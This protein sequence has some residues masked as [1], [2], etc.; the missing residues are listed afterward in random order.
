M[1]EFNE[2]QIEKQLS[3]LSASRDSSL[4][5]GGSTAIQTVSA[6][7]CSEAI[8]QHDSAFSLA[9]A[10]DVG[11]L[12]SQRI[13][14]PQVAKGAAQAKGG[15]NGKGAPA[16]GGKKGAPAPPPMDQDVD[17][18]PEP[19][20]MAPEPVHMA[21]EPVVVTPPAKGKG[22]GGK[23]GAPSITPSAPPASGKGVPAAP[24]GKGVPAAPGGGKGGKA[25]PPAAG[26]KGKPGVKGKGKGKGA[27]STRIKVT[28]LPL[29]RRVNLKEGLK[30]E[31]LTKSIWAEG[32]EKIRADSQKQLDDEYLR[33]HFRKAE[34]VKL[35]IVK[36]EDSED[37][38]VTFFSSGQIQNFKI[39]WSQMKNKLN[40]EEIV[41]SLHTLQP[42]DKLPSEELIR[43][44]DVIPPLSDMKNLAEYDGPEE[45]LRETER[46]LYP[47]SLNNKSY[48]KIK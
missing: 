45:N 26:G 6:T 2:I 11:F 34:K 29:N 39:V 7:S 17:M 22:K 19:R 42:F 33:S 28:D 31:D 18:A 44:C 16:K 12:E 3:G 23:P 30:S 24:G 47:I 48:V 10:S 20:D 21:P 38:E 8:L 43:F 46:L 36:K 15:K 4:S 40:I 13:E 35:A 14:I 9:S 5:P 37:N 41:H 27:A 32:F 1:V 25:A